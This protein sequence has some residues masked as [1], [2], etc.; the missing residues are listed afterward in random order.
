M[1]AT[2]RRKTVRDG[3]VYTP[4]G[5]EPEFLFEVIDGLVER[6]T[7][8]AHEVGIANMLKDLLTPVVTERRDGR[9]YVELGYDLPKTNHARRKPDVS[10]LSFKRWP[11]EKRFPKGD[12]IPAAPDLAVEVI[13]PHEKV[14]T[15]NRKLRDYFRG[16]VRVVW[17]VL[18]EAE[19]VHAYTSVKDVTILT[20]DDVLTGDPVVPGFRIPVA[21]LFAVRA[22]AE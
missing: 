20:R 11:A 16:G 14:S 4:D 15:T 1:P 7:V 13:S 19:Q 22:S 10:V 2:V 12:F 21:A 5:P 17:L 9:V 8:G 6:K 3:D 18:P